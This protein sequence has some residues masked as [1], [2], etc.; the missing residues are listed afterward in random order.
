MDRPE[1]IAY[2]S[3]NGYSGRLVPWLYDGEWVYALNIYDPWGDK[4]LHAGM[5]TAR[6]LEELKENVDGFPA[7]MDVLNGIKEDDDD[8]DD[9]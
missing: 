2:Q 1:I 8:S 6:T 4:V 9:I 3:E 7:F 5:A